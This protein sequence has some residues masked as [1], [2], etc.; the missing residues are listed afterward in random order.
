MFTNV[1]G[2][3]VG[4]RVVYSRTWRKSSAKHSKGFYDQD[5]RPSLWC[6]TKVWDADLDG[7]RNLNQDELDR[8]AE[9]FKH[10]HDKDVQFVFSRCQHH[11]HS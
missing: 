8:E 5:T 4:I 10:Y 11:W 2:Y 6:P 7:V 9:Q 1:G 3:S